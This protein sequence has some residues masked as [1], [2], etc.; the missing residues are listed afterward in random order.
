MEK[1]H[2]WIRKLQDK[3]EQWIHRD[4]AQ[5]K[6][7][8]DRQAKK[9][10]L[11]PIHERPGVVLS[12]PGQFGRLQSSCNSYCLAQWRS[13]SNSCLYRHCRAGETGALDST[14]DFVTT[15]ETRELVRQPT[16]AI[17]FL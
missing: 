5:G 4:A 6:T 11:Q 8:L 17:L 7:D 2:S 14:Q 12:D 10:L 15:H 1:A 3:R 9:K 16:P 13:C